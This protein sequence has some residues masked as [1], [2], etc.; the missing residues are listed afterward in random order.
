MAL[1]E[2]QQ[3]L[4]KM[5]KFFHE[6]CVSNCLSY[7]VVGG[8]ALGSIRH[9]GFIPW[10]DDIDV[11][12]PRNDYTKF[13]HL[14]GNDAIHGYIVE[15]LNSKDKS[16]CYAYTKLYD[17]STTLI[18]NTKKRIKRGIYI[19][20][21]PLDGVGDSVIEAKKI[22]API[23]KKKKLL[24]LRTIKTNSKRSLCKNF[25]L[26]VI[27]FLPNFLIDEKRICKQ[28]DELCQ[29]QNFDSSALVGNLVGAWGWKEIM[30]KEI[31]GR[32]TLYKFET[33]EVYGPENFDEYLSH[34][35]GDWRK[36]PPVEKRVPHHDYLLDLTKSYL[37]KKKGCQ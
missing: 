14:F 5:L 22:F 30:P 35:Y 15:S 1:T 37:I 34:L 31:F 20:I 8:T 9:Q 32:P 28:I 10:D 19:D 26:S 24:S 18:E 11:G 23:D 7:Y 6:F 36:L 12:M 17:T 21:F 3:K 25:I 29:K 16:F 2:M 33:I 4:L 13:I 27:Q